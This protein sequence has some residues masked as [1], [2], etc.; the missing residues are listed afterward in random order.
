MVSVLA[1]QLAIPQ[2][3]PIIRTCGKSMSIQIGNGLF[4]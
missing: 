1:S 3:G 4:Q 2:G